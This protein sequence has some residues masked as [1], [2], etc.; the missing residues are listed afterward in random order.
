MIPINNK[1]QL[2]IKPVLVAG[3]E[4]GAI[5]EIGTIIAIGDYMD[6]EKWQVGKKLLFKA[7]AVDIITLG[8]AKSYYIDGLS[9][10]ICAI[11][12]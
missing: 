7:W 4:T 5:E 2:D 1:I 3:L 9:D 6:A 12:K 11:E 10:G 8:E